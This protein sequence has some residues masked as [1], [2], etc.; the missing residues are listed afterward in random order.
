MY[1]EKEGLVSVPGG[2]NGRIPWGLRGY[3]NTHA[4]VI[5]RVRGFQRG[6]RHL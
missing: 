2:C 4:G 3:D 1:Y 5:R 6:E